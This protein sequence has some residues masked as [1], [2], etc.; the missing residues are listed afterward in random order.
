MQLHLAYPL[1]SALF[2]VATLCAVLIR[3]FVT[4]TPFYRYPMAQALSTLH[5]YTNRYHKKVLFGLRALLLLGLAFLIGRP[6]WVDERSVINID[7]VDIVLA[8]D[9]SE[10]MLCFDDLKDPRSRLEVAKTEAIRFIEKR[11]NDPIAITVFGREAFSRCPLTLDKTMLKEL[12]S[13]IEIGMI[14]PRG[15]WL[16]TGLA[17]AIN[18]IKN[19]KAKSKIILLLTDGRPTPPEKVEPQMA[20]ELAKQ[21][22]V[23]IYAIGIGNKNGGYFDH[24][25]FGVQQV[26][27]S[28]D[29]A[30]LQKI[31]Q[32]SGGK[33]FRADNPKQMRDIYD[34]IDKLEKTKHETNLFSKYYEAF[35]TF[36]WYLVILLISEYILRMTIWRGL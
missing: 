11:T 15:T 2:L 16:G 9:V 31:A 32:E 8:L 22:G 33:Y 36:I 20:I 6:Q 4:K 1:V 13:S 28:V 34:T 35:R 18:R 25:F 19:S 29:E 3:I 26:Q 24:S 14:D 10:S 27:D 17:T 23:K 7:G 21:F 12:V 30:L 5:A